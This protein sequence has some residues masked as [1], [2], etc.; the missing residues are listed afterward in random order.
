MAPGL[1]DRLLEVDL[2]RQHVDVTEIPPGWQRRYLGGKGLGAR[3]LYD[4]V[5][6]DTLP[7]GAANV[8]LVLVGPLTGYLPGDA[9]FAAVT[10]S[11]L[12][13]LFLDSY[14]GGSFGRSLRGSMPRYA[15][16]AISGKTDQTTILDLRNEEPQL[17]PRPDL[18]GESVDTVDDEFGAASVL[19]V[20][21][22]GEAG[23]P[24]ATIAGDG[25]DHHAGRGGAGAV[26]GTKGLKA[27]VVDRTDEIEPPTPAIQR[28]HD[29]LVAAYETSPYGESHRS[30][31]TLETVE[32]ADSTGMLSS[33]AW[34]ERGFAGAKS[35]GIEAVRRS[36]TER[37]DDRGP[38]PGDYRVESDAGETV[39]RGGAPIALGANLGV[40]DFDA[41]ATLGTTCDQLGLDVISAGNVVALAM[42]ASE[43][44]AIDRSIEFGDETD[45][46][47]LISE[48][49][50]RSSGL[51]NTL[52]GGVEAAA[53]D[54]GLDEVVPTVKAMEV[55]SFDPR[56]APAMAL[57]YATSD[58][59]ACHRRAVPA[60][61]QVFEP[62]WTPTQTAEAVVAEQNR[63]AALWCLIVDDL[64]T[65]IIT[66]IGDIW[67]EAIGVDVHRGEL[68]RIGERTWTLT[69]LFNV[70]EGVAREDDRLPSAFTGA[71][72]IDQVW[73]DRARRR[74]YE[75]RDWDRQGRP[76]RRLLERLDI[77]ELIDDHT[78]V[79]DHP[80]HADPN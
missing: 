70:R 77:D 49:A 65:P 62:T 46:E 11:P 73:F 51:G 78:P 79:G 22:A 28:L 72:G 38:I 71:D 18:A 48:I 32:F 44:G 3:Y 30:S 74:Y 35:L 53:A 25:G 5:G 63:R 10:K 36:A 34:Q 64:A 4:R 55:P 68:D 61:A 60:T 13:G 21:P 50:F 67:S 33:F 23:V 54:L 20:G 17:S 45:A 15:G 6:S 26:M 52:A 40:D 59:G 76:S 43:R 7:L 14:A 37:E 19:T 27:I 47:R 56:G 80:L 58:R 31:G 66:E 75:L 12:T 29:A 9:R 16:L 2:T 39:I 41:V 1:V 57:A 8:L 69:R 24:F 42:L